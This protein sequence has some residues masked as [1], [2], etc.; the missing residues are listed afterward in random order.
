MLARR[1]LIIG[2][3]GVAAAA[4]NARAQTTAPPSPV[5]PSPTLAFPTRPVRLVVGIP[6][7]GAPDVIARLL[8]ERLSAAWGH[9]VVVDNRPAA[10][11]NLAAQAVARGEPDGHTLFFAHASVL[12]LNEVLTRDV[13]FNG[14]RDFAPISLLMTTPFMLACRPDF[15]AAT[16]ADLRA[17][18]RGKPGGITFATLSA[19]GLP[20]FVVERVRAALGVE[21]TNVPYASMSGAVQDVIAGRVDLL[22]DGTP[23]IAPQVRAGALKA[24]AITSPTR[25][26]ALPDVPA[27]AESVPGF[28]SKGWF[29]LLAPAATPG[30]VVRRIA[31]DARQ[32]LA[33]PALRARLLRDFGA[34][35]VAGT[36]GEFAASLA[37]DRRIY[38]EVV[39]QTG[40]LAD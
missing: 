4:R 27:A 1:T 24:L 18:A 12:L 13:P 14:E 25:D 17:A 28:S 16:L 8:A 2:A 15:P 5:P 29:G 7:G 31:A 11:G 40:I 23:V 35:T 9:P 36:P 22:A 10:S 33:E 32:V 34:D 38:R 26:P 30:P 19:T 3:G 6:P 21:M 20:R 39:R 37:E